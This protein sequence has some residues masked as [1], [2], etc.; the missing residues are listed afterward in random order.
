M[1]YSRLVDISELKGID[2]IV[3]S[4]WERRYIKRR[5]SQRHLYFKK[6]LKTRAETNFNRHFRSQVNC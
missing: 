5:Q 3:H 1:K 4:L 2:I 6:L